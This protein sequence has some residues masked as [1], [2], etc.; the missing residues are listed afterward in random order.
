MSDFTFINIDVCADTKYFE[1]PTWL[2]APPW[3]ADAKAAA[4]C[5]G[6]IP[7]DCNE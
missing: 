3:V 1:W 4:S 2:V 7:P 5:D 6:V